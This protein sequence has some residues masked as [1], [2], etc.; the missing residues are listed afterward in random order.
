MNSAVLVVAVLCAPAPLAQRQPRV[1]Q[2]ELTAGNY[3]VSW[4]SSVDM[5]GAITGPRHG[6]YYYNDTKY[7][8]IWE[9]DPRQRKF[10]MWERAEHWCGEE[11]MLTDRRDMMMKYVFYLDSDLRTVE[12]PKSSTY[13]HMKRVK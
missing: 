1:K 11:M 7:F 8:F 4:G 12:Y 6:W 5:P 10:S 3:V 13:L 2:A 9:W